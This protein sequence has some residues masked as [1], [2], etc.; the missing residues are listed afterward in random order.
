MGVNYIWGR[1]DDGGMAQQASD[2]VLTTDKRIAESVVQQ[3][4][5][6]LEITDDQHEVLEDGWLGW[7]D[8]STEHGEVVWVPGATIDE[9]LAQHDR[10]TDYRAQ[11]SRALRSEGYTANERKQT[12]IDGARVELYPFIPEVLDN[13]SSLAD[14]IAENE[15]VQHLADAGLLTERQAEAYVLRDIQGASRPVAA[16]KMGISVNTLDDRLSEARLKVDK[17]RDT[18]EIVDG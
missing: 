1:S 4:S 5:E 11:V 15:Q 13:S 8:P 2:E 17:A 10:G 12:T 18:I 7:Y 9:A 16:R 14:G 6:R 3:F